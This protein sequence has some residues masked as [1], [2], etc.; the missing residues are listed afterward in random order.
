MTE[1]RALDCWFAPHLYIKSLPR[2]AGRLDIS[3]GLPVL[4]NSHGPPRNRDI[5][6]TTRSKRHGVLLP[7][8]GIGSRS[9][10]RCLSSAFYL[11]RPTRAPRSPPKIGRAVSS[12]HLPCVIIVTAERGRVSTRKPGCNTRSG[13]VPEHATD[14]RRKADARRGT[15]V[16]TLKHPWSVSQ[17][18]SPNP[19]LQN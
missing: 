11:R 6:P 9:F 5:C 16:N 15:G 4:F 7:V 8:L 13:W 14:P 1:T 12:T 3:P 17:Q 10:L 18:K 19:R 2:Q